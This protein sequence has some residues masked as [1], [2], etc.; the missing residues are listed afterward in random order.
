MRVL[1]SVAYGGHV[2]LRTFCILD[3]N[4]YVVQ[5]DFAKTQG[6]TCDTD[7]LAGHANNSFLGHQPKKLFVAEKKQSILLPLIICDCFCVET[8]PRGNL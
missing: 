3:G 2:C 1:S 8:R 4:S 5:S 6:D 7:R